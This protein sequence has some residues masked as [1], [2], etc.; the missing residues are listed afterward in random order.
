[1]RRIFKKQHFVCDL[2]SYVISCH[3]SHL[4]G[5]VDR[6]EVELKLVQEE[7]EE[8]KAEAV[9]ERNERM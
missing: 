5:E 4:T 1:M 7:K 3:T 9:I 2:L 6:A 8:T